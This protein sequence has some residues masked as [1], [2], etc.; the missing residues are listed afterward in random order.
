L[1]Y[2]GAIVGAA[3]YFARFTR[4]TSDYFFGGR[5]FSGWLI[6]VSCV[7]TTIGAYSFVKYGSAAFSYGFASSMTYLNDWFWMPLW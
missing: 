3:A 4:T 7:A 2:F 5:R 6:A 1:L